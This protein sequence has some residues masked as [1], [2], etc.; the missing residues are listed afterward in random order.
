MLYQ[1]RAFRADRWHRSFPA[2]A[3]LPLLH[4][5]RPP[6]ESLSGRRPARPVT[7]GPEL[8]DGALPYPRREGADRLGPGVSSA[9]FSRC[10]PAVPRLAA[11]P[12][13]DPPDRRAILGPRPDQRPQ[14]GPGAHRVA[15]R[16]K[17][18]PRRVP[19]SPARLR[20]R[21]ADR[22]AWTS[23][24]RGV[25]RLARP[26]RGSRPAPSCRPGPHP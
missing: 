6:P 24:R 8:L 22:A 16:P 10:R 21:G 7:P 20:G 26:P 15:L 12:R 5:A 17:G 4:D 2:S 1:L 13:P 3:A 18:L 9:G 25:A 19:Q 14:R 11:T 23:L